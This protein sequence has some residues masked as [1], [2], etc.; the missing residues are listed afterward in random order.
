MTHD[1]KNFPELTDTQML[2]Y[3][4]DS[5]HKQITENIFA[6]V[7]K[8]LDGDTIKVKWAE[9]DFEFPVRFANIAAPEKKEEGGLESKL[10]LENRLLGKEIFIAINPR[11]RVGKWGRLIGYIL[12]SGIDVGKESIMNGQSVA[13]ADIDKGKIIDNIQL[14]KEFR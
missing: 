2:H 1:F 9:R 12:E 11:N 3:Y 6:I 5:P 13:W 8:V 7:T 4:F 14:P 10:W